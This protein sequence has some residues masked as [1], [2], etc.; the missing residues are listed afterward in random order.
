MNNFRFRFILVR[1]DIL[2]ICCYMLIGLILVLVAGLRPVEIGLDSRAYAEF[3]TTYT[4]WDQFDFLSKEPGFWIL[5]DLNKKIFSGSIQSF[6]LI[7]AFIAITLKFYAYIRL[8]PYP[9]LSIILY[10]GMFFMLHEMNQ[11]RAGLASG[12]IL[13]A[14]ID[15]KNDYQNKYFIKII[16][17]SIF[18]Y[19]SILFLLFLF[20]KGNRSYKAIYAF[21]PVFGLMT[22]LLSTKIIV[23]FDYISSYFPMFIHNKISTYLLL[24][25]DGILDQKLLI[26]NYGTIAYSFLLYFLLYCS[27]G[28][29]TIENILIKMLSIQVFLGLFL[30]FN[31]ELS[32][33]VYTLL[34]VVTFVLAPPY[35]LKYIKP[36][37]VMV[38]LICMYSVKQ[39]IANYHT[40]L[41]S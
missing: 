27:D 3:V 16:L 15:Y 36:P 29:D 19:S 8:S 28:G 20:L 31:V 32:N 2:N 30:S 21:L 23:H 10:V 40:V 18:H 37:V 9:F 39:L 34:G 14:F 25:E 26:F 24:Q 22:A 33:R 7:Y 35:V 38:F 5:L 6:F 13:L 4:G 11:I 12:I 41:F 1:E 17:A